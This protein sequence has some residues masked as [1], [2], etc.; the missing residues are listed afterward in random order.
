MRK[1]Q[2]KSAP[3]LRRGRSARTARDRAPAPSRLGRVRTAARQR[4]RT[5]RARRSLVLRVEELGGQVAL[6]GVR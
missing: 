4:P 3:R 6:A 5:P 1:D 2:A